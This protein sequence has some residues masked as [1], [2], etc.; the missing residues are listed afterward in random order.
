MTPDQAFA[1]ALE[2]ARAL[3]PPPPGSGPLDAFRNETTEWLAR[4]PEPPLYPRADDPVRARAA[5]LLDEGIGL[6]GRGWALQ[7]AARLD[8]ADLPLVRAVQA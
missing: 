7:Q 3:G 2:R 8:D 1:A 4:I 6:L 5:E